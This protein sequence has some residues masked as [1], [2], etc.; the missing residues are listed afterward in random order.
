MT[1]DACICM[2]RTGDR[3]KLSGFFGTNLVSFDVQDAMYMYETTASV[4]R[5][6]CKKEPMLFS[7]PQQ[8]GTMKS[9]LPVLEKL[10]ILGCCQGTIKVSYQ[11]AR[12]T[13]NPQR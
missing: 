12:M 10:H 7:M 2:P 3:P 9:R 5:E 4:E 11:N 8:H 1:R 6:N 13:L